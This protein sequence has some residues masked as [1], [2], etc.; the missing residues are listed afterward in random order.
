[1]TYAP[2]LCKTTNEG[3][4]SFSHTKVHCGARLHELRDVKAQGFEKLSWGST[5]SAGYPSRSVRQRQDVT[6]NLRKNGGTDT[7]ARTILTV[8]T[9]TVCTE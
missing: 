5:G 7:Y 2:Q 8:K 6:H 4:L 1:M 3:R 9:H